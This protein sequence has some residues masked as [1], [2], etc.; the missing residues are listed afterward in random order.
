MS[1]RRFS[2][3]TG[4]FSF[5]LSHS[6]MLPVVSSIL[7][8][9]D[10]IARCHPRSRRPSIKTSLRPL[11]RKLRAGD[12]NRQGNLQTRLLR[13]QVLHRRP[14]FESFH[15][16][17]RGSLLSRPSV[18][19]KPPSR[20]FA[21]FPRCRNSSRGKVTRCDWRCCR[22]SATFSSK[23]P[24]RRLRNL[25]RKFPRSPIMRQ[26]RKIAPV[27]WC[28]VSRWWK[29]AKKRGKKRKK[30]SP[31]RESISKPRLPS[32]RC[33]E[34]VRKISTRSSERRRYVR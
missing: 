3:P 14:Q 5:F 4:F 29:R 26:W 27:F 16:N 11:Q 20:F 6:S 12:G 9:M 13:I 30:K 7:V 33:F 19:S 34:N 24:F 15:R 32:S 31:R 18:R 23:R 10:G 28:V 1:W 22:V 25:P 17:P 21:H 2:L 8:S